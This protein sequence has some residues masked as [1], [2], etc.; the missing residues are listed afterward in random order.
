MLVIAICM[1]IRSYQSF[2][3]F[4]W[5]RRPTGLFLVGTLRGQ[6]VLMSLTADWW[7]EAG[8][9]HGNPG[10]NP[11]W[12]ES[13]NDVFPGRS[14]NTKFYLFQL[15]TG[16]FQQPGVGMTMLPGETSPVES[17]HAIVVPLW[18]IS[19]IS[20]ILPTHLLIRL[21][22]TT[23]A[24]LGLCPNCHY[25]LRAHASGNNCPECGTPITA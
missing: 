10:G 3:R 12:P 16:F 8:F 7:Y 19:F 17:F 13:L 9:A 14:T 1:W 18:L 25:D 20:A 5:S 22:R 2:D 23:R 24:N 4:G 15:A 11:N 21:R 6:I